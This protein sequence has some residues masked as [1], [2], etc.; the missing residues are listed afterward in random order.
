M[1]QL[2]NYSNL[3]ERRAKI[4]TQMRI[5]LALDSGSVWRRGWQGSVWCAP[6]GG[7]AAAAGRQRLLHP[8]VKVLIWG[9]LVRFRCL[10][11]R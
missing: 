4:N 1:T 9:S 11:D 2:R 6:G 8:G 7:E 3:G 5:Y 10:P